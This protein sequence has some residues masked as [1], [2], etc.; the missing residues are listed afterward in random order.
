[1]RNTIR[2]TAER[3]ET[4]TTGIEFGIQFKNINNVDMLKG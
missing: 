2:G 3:R 4:L 1:M